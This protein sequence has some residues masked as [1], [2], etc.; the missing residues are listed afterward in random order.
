M[1]IRSC[2]CSCHIYTTVRYIAFRCFIAVFSMFSPYYPAER[3]D[4]FHH[5]IMHLCWI[6]H[7]DFTIRL[8]NPARTLFNSILSNIWCILMCNIFSGFKWTENC[9]KKLN[10]IRPQSLKLCEP[11]MQAQVERM[12]HFHIFKNFSISLKPHYLLIVCI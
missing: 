10:W 11:Y 8:F 4:S 3:E 2:A 7:L 6:L 5:F 12:I 1:K 9:K